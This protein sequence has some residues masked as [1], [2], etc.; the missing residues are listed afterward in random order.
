MAPTLC[1]L[2]RGRIKPE[3][4]VCAQ[5]GLARFRIGR[6]EAKH[7]DEADEPAQI[8]GCPARARQSAK[9]VPRHQ[10][11]HHGIVEDR[12]KFDGK[13]AQRVARQRHGNPVAGA[14]NGPP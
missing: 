6:H 10:R 11:A 2:A 1:P 8:A 13:R 7:H 4:R 9:P 14:G 5:Q 12:G 3:K